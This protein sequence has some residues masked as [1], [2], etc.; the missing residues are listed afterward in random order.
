MGSVA[1]SLTAMVF[2]A[3]MLVAGWKLVTLTLFFA[4]FGTG[5]IVS[6]F[7]VSEL[8]NTFP[9]LFNCWALTLA[10]LIGG[11]VTGAI[12]RKFLKWAFF[13]IGASVGMVFGFYAYHLGL[14]SYEVQG[15]SVHWVYWACMLVP[16]LL[17]GAVSVKLESK[18]LAFSTS[19]IG[20]FAFVIGVDYL[21]LQHIDPRFTEWISLSTL[22]QG[23]DGI[24]QQHAHLDGFTLGPIISALMLSILGVMIQLRLQDGKSD[25]EFQPM[26]IGNTQS[27]NS[28]YYRGA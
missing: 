22:A 19:L 20:G 26:L 5:F 8:F 2:G 25:D 28:G 16:A 10:P 7:A 13:L 3:L 24:D 14:D 15:G 11:L 12:V 17:C 27:R 18:I 4:G 9:S 23:G 21:I 6:F 1:F